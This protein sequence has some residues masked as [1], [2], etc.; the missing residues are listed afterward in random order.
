MTT[1]GTVSEKTPLSVLLFNEAIRRG[2]SVSDFAE[3]IGVGAISLRQFISNKTQRPRTKTLDQIAEALNMPSEDVRRRMDLRPEAMPPFGEWLKQ[4]MDAK[5][6]KRARL[7]K[8]SG[9]SDGALKNYLN[10]QT[11][12]D[13]QQAQR[14]AEILGAS[15]MDLARV[16]VASQVA[17]EGG[18]MAPPEPEP[19]EAADAT[20]GASGGEAGEVA[21]VLSRGQDDDQLLTLWRRLH[22]Q[23]R[24][25]TIHYIAGLLAEG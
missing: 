2:K 20:D 19:D 15:S 6:F 4:R 14:L 10:G 16:I 21:P 17:K 13:S 11:L 1:N 25:A 24:R 18:E 22:P 23:G 12:P 9:I 3:E 8:E 5:S 7:A